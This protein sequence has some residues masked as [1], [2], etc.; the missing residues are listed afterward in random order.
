MRPWEYFN[1]FVGGPIRAYLYFS[2]EGVDQRVK[3]LAA[4][5]YFY[6]PISEVEERAHSIDWLGR[7]PGRDQSRLE[8]A[9]FPA[10]DR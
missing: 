5:I 10:R 4:I 1:E 6:G 8:S 9:R 3:E 7:D 2:D